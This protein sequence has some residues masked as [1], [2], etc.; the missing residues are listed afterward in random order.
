MGQE[1]QNILEQ[2][3]RLREDGA[4]LQELLL[5][6][7]VMIS[8][9]PSPT[10]HEERRVRFLQD[11]F[12]ECGLQN[13]STDEVGNGVA[14]LPGEEGNDNI[15]V[16]AHADT[17]VSEQMDH[18]IAVEPDRIVGPGVG[19]NSLGVAVLASLPT[20][21]ERLGLK[22]KSN[23]ILLGASRGL[24]RGNLEGLRFFLA[25]NDMPIRSGV[26]IEGVQLGR[27]SHTSIGMLR[28]D[29]SC[30]VP[31]EYD[32]TRFGAFGAITII[33]EVI[34]RMI[35]ISLPKRPSTSIVFGTIHGGKSYGAIATRAVLGFEI[36]SESGETVTQI[37]QQI[38]DI[39]GEVSAR[40]RAE[41][42]LDIFARRE[43]GGIAFGHPLCRCTRA[44]MEALDI[45]A[46]ISPSMSELAAFIDKGIP[47]ITLGISRG[48]RLHEECESVEIEP[49]FTGLAQFVGVLLAMD[50]GF[51]DGP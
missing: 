5:A 50:G 44:I 23:L 38:E 27:L 39:T 3:P 51:T 33:N 45:E 32:W 41:V 47:A 22:L 49:M 16:V 6:N 43:P 31:E 28:G 24:G 13:C 42:N 12:S 4:A 25:N 37:Q 1:F 30:R 14:I 35:A 17:V 15:L 21:L 26:C 8:E 7:L 10:F 20:L 11:R 40:T 29:I 2:L 34:N 9:I 48:E 18:T 36:R 46:R 19:D